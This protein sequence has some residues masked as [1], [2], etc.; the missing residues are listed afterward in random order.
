MD[1]SKYL[2]CPRCHESGLYC[3]KH[4]IEVESSL[5]KREIRKILKIRDLNSTQYRHAIRGLL[6]SY[7]VWTTSV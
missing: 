1:Y 2:N 3:P 6:Q 4:R 7:D 5:R